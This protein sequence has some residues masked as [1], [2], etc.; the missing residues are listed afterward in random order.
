MIG[1]K[2]AAMHGGRWLMGECCLLMDAPNVVHT[3]SHGLCTRTVEVAVGGSVINGAI[4]S[5]LHK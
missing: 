1:S 4:L 5:S 3:T 2:G